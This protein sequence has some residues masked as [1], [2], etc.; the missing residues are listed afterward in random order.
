MRTG[1]P[2]P[3]SGCPPIPRDEL[4][5]GAAARTIRLSSIPPAPYH[6]TIREAH[7]LSTTACR[8]PMNH[9]VRPW[10]I[11]GFLTA[12]LVGVPQSTP[13]AAQGAGAIPH[14]AR[15]GEAVHLMVDGAPFLILGG[16]LHNSSASSLAYMEDVWPTLQQMNLNT[17]LAVVSW[18]EVETQEGVFDFSVVDGLIEEARSRD[19]R[20]IL[21]WFGSWKNGLSHY[22]PSWVKSDYRRFPR[23]RLSTGTTEVLSTFSEANLQADARAFAAFMRHLREVDSSRHTVV[24]VQVENEVGLLGD[25]RDRSPAAEAAFSRPVPPELIRYLQA[26]RAS[27]LPEL[28]QVWEAAGRRTSG[29]WAQVF[30]EGAAAEEAF[31]AWHYARYLDGVAAAGKAEYP[32]PMFVNAWIVQPQDVTP[33]DYPSGGPQSHVHDIWKAG[34]P[35]IDIL[36]PDIYLPD[37][38]SITAQYRRSGTPLFVPESVAGAAGAANAFHAIGRHHALGY[39]P[40][41]IET[42][43]ADPGSGPLS[44]AYAV[45]GQLAPLITEH[46]AA[47]TIDAVWLQ[48]DAPEQEIRLGDY[49]LRATL[50][51]ARGQA[52]AAQRGYAIFMNVGP[53]EFLVAGS[54]LQV[55]FTPATAGPPIAGLATVDEGT[56]ADGE[57][58]AGRRLNGDQIMIS[59]DMA[60]L[61]SQRQTG[62]GL[63]FTADPT[64]LRVKLYRYE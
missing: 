41:G 46:Q 44:L 14:L 51:Q 8:T 58:I 5:A 38:P 53:D 47:G 29:S 1:L 55:T 42:R 40:F 31:M 63:R 60:E 57:W 36:A 32:L 26:E 37:F 12:L 7:P 4:D 16:E 52:A 33:G 6:C 13:A 28:A 62:T 54:D 49:T 43:E 30:G 64:I 56:F 9:S 24:M 18:G 61:A 45:L 50:R 11:C 10:L 35:H 25:A 3:T 23:A 17:V 39:S 19:L 20:L 34:A 27:L 15:N 21:L 2:R 22:A 59:Y 48:P